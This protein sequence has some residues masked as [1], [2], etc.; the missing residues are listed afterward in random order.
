[1]EEVKEAGVTQAPASESEQNK[2]EVTPTLTQEQV[3][4]IVSERLQKQEAKFEERLKQEKADAERQAKMT[5]EE[6]EK[7]M[8][9]K[10]RQEISLKEKEILLRENKLEAHQKLSELGMPIDFADF[11]ISR[12][13]QKQNERIEKLNAKFSEAVA[14][15]VESRLKGK[16]PKD[17]TANESKAPVI[18]GTF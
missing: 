14:N 8:T 7:E 17:Y 5:A 16:A 11:V 15:S 6:R 9:E 2:V 18:R 12:D 10:A 4:K 13:L 3:D 1:M